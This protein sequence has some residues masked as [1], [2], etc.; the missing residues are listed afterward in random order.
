MTKKDDA[1]NGADL[2]AFSLGHGHRFLSLRPFCA[3][4]SGGWERRPFLLP[5]PP[6]SAIRKGMATLGCGL[7]S[8]PLVPGG[9]DA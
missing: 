4:A 8:A 9:H 3:S 1:E 2:S 5:L 6:P 7:R